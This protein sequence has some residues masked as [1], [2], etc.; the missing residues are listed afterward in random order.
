[1]TQEN[2]PPVST[3]LFITLGTFTNQAKSF[4][5]S[6]SNL[7]LVD[8]NE[9]VGLVLQHYEQFDSRYKGILSLK[10]VYIP[11]EESAA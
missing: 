11:D 2:R 1:M 7:R 4:A 9:L 10:R 8:G 6:K 5:K 3:G